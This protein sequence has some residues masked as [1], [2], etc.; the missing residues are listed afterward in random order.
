V[1]K[2]I[3]TE[4]DERLVESL[5]KEFDPKTHPIASQIADRLPAT[6][7]EW[8]VRTLRSYVAD[9]ARKAIAARAYIDAILEA[10]L[11]NALGLEAF[12][13]GPASPGAFNFGMRNS[14]EDELLDKLEHIRAP[15]APAHR[16][17]YCFEFMSEVEDAIDDRVLN[18]LDPWRA[19]A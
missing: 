11:V 18:D 16:S 17:C 7:W 19:N 8:T 4:E 3:F 2:L 13:H 15:G 6:E 12:F 5:V 14:R 10:G 1:A 9:R